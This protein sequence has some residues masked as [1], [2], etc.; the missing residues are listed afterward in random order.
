MLL[1]KQASHTYILDL[2]VVE[3]KKSIKKRKRGQKVLLAILNNF[4]HN[5]Y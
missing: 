5:T 2:T 3:L 4:L 1:R